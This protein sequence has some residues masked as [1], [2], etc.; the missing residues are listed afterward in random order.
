MADQRENEKEIN[1]NEPLVSVILVTYQ[2]YGGIYRVLDS[3]FVQTYPNME[4]IIQDDGS[5]NFSQYSNEIVQYIQDNKG[6]NIK[7]VVVNHL[8]ENV[9]TSKN[10]NA[11]IAL[12]TGKYIKFLNSDDELYDSTVI[13]SCVEYC[14]QYDA[15]ILVGQTYVKPRN[16]NSVCQPKDS[17]WYRW[18]ARSGRMS[19]ITPPKRDISYLAKLPHKQ[20]NDLLASRCIISTVSVFYR[21]DVF[22]E[23][24]G[25]PEAYKYIEDMPFWPYLAKRGE[26]FHFSH[27]IM[28]MYELNGIS[29]GGE[30][31]REF[32]REACDI[33]RTIYIPN[34]IRGGILNWLI[35]KE[36]LREQDYIEYGPL[37]KKTDKI[38]YI[39][40]IISK[41][42]KNLKYLL[43]GT[44]L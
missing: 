33:V 2:K 41:F 16:G 5:S 9:G 37:L 35:K 39:D 13:E 10:V 38:K 17:V 20:C 24:K 12:A 18:K 8:E 6:S 14:E 34:E 32:L 31:K 30:L 40:V 3:L 25:F 22:E 15:R 26:Y 36:R 42:I 28:M 29:N 23:T 1:Q 7:N 27:I 19:T 21:V 43:F 44:K 11:G 4:L